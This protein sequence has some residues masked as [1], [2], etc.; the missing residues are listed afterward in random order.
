MD[1]DTRKTLGLYVLLLKQIKEQKDGANG[2]QEKREDNARR[3]REVE[4]LLGEARISTESGWK[5][6]NQIVLTRRF[7]P[8]QQ[9]IFTQDSEMFEVFINSNGDMEKGM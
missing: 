3:G 7:P 8:S 6:N 4:D 1:S 9:R 5:G 2:L